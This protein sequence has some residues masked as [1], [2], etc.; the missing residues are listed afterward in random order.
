MGIDIETYRKWIEI[1]MTPEMNCSNIEV[2]HVKPIC[3][4]NISDDNQ[5]KNAFNWEN[6]QPLQKDD[7][8]K[9]GIKYNFLNYQLQF[10]KAYQFIK[11]NKEGL[12]QDFY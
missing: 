10:I 8:Q 7:H 9:K 12:N 3:M 4:F 2:D 5:L 11:L 1:Q 6:T